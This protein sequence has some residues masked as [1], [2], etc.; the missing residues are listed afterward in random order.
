MKFVTGNINLDFQI[1]AALKRNTSFGNFII[2][3]S[4]MQYFEFYTNDGVSIQSED[5]Y[6][7][8]LRYD[9]SIGTYYFYNYLQLNNTYKNTGY[10]EEYDFASDI[11][12]GCYRIKAGNY[13]SI[14]LVRALD[15]DITS[16]LNG[17]IHGDSD[18]DYFGDSDGDYFG[19][20]N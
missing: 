3:I 4:Q 17:F 18:G 10:F 8:K 14:T 19:E 6:L 16:M 7:Q 9:S 11:D 2:P 15:I 20:T 12:T 5:F 1:Q 13:Y